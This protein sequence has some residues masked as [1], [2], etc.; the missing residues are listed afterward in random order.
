MGTLADEKPLRVAPWDGQPSFLASIIE[1]WKDKGFEVESLPLR[2][3]R[4]I[5][6]KQ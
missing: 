1:L 3:G 2:E 5:S 4:L 6:G